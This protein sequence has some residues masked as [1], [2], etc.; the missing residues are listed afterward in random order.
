MKCRKHCHVMTLELLGCGRGRQTGHIW[1]IDDLTFVQL[2]SQCCTLS[3]QMPHRPSGDVFWSDMRIITCRRALTAPF[4]H[5][6]SHNESCENNNM[7]T[8]IQ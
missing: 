4:V 5:H 7:G 1:F 3:V 8:N 6:D 2:T